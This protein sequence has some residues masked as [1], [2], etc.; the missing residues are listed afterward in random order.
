MFQAG[1]NLRLEQE[2]AESFGVAPALRPNPFVGH[3][4]A[5]LFVASQED[6]SQ[7]AFSMG[8]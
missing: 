7:T 5:K 8:A 4:A 6:F 1:G 3:V 2:A